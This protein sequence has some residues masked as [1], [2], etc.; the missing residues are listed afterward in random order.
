MTIEQLETAI[1]AAKKDG[2]VDAVIGNEGDGIYFYNAR[3]QRLGN[4]DEYNEEY[5]SFLGKAGS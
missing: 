2:A 5:I 4:L 3:G 1:T